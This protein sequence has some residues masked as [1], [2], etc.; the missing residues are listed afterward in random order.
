MAR[1]SRALGRDHMSNSDTERAGGV[2]KNR[3]VCESHRTR[4]MWT[5][6]E[7]KENFWSR[8]WLAILERATPVG[9]WQVT[10]GMRVGC[11]ERANGCELQSFEEDARV[12]TEP[13]RQ[14][15]SLTESSE[16]SRA[17]R[18]QESHPRGQATATHCTQ[19]VGVW[20]GIT[21]CSSSLTYAT[22]RLLNI[23]PAPTPPA[24]GVVTPM[25]PSSH[26]C[27]LLQEGAYLTP[28]I[29]EGSPFQLSPKIRGQNNISPSKQIREHAEK[30]SKKANISALPVPERRDSLPNPSPRPATTKAPPLKNREN[31]FH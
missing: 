19:N 24:V 9:F 22:Y 11:W 8:P 20:R 21:A 30:T 13:D 5:P 23:G 12:P 27:F 14:W 17:S 26:A 25:K 15:A 10:K 16:E 7:G 2:T 1:R 18:E 6:R 29:L 31:Q 4:C 28:F 3:N